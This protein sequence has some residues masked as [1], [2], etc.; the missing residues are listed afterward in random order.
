[1]FKK[2]PKV[3]R[4]KI[5]EEDIKNA[6]CNN[7]SQCILALAIRRQLGINPRYLRVAENGIGFSWNGVKYD[8]AT[9]TTALKDI[10]KFD[11][12]DGVV[13]PEPGTTY[14][15]N[16]IRSKKIPQKSSEQME[17]IYENRR[18]NE[19]RRK[20]EGIPKPEYRRSL[21]VPDFV[22]SDD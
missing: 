13:T 7:R 2:A 11:L 3:L 19:I 12:S 6:K 16:F 5:E 22:F 10:H 14:G 18:K 15:L 17:K 20:A 21:D 4:L 8:F 9:P 1:M